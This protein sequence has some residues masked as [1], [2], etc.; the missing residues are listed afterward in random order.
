MATKGKTGFDVMYSGES[1]KPAKIVEQRG[2]G[3]VEGDGV[4]L[5]DNANTMRSGNPVKGLSSGKRN[6]TEDE[7]EQS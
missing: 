2:Y 5:V 7:L 3:L 4:G 1:S 6:K